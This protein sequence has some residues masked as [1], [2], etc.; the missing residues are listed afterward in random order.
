MDIVLDVIL[1][2]IL[3]AVVISS[4]KKGI[5]KTLAELVAF[6]VAIFLASQTA[7]PVASGMYK[8][9]FSKNVERGL[10][11]VLPSDTSKL[12]NTDKAKYVFEEMPEFANKQAEKCGISIG[13]VA[14]Q[15]AKSN[16]SDGDTLYQS[17]ESNI[18]KPIAVAVL[19]HV[20]F[21]VLSVLYALVLVAI[22]RSLA[23]GLKKSHLI[24]GA[25]KLVGGVIGVVKGV[26]I[27][28]LVGCLL[29][30]L[31]PRI[32]NEKLKQAVDGSS[33]VEMC[34][35]FDPME[36]ISAAE[37]FVSNIK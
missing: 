28:F 29:S 3:I 18:V 10:Y 9:F 32:E 25:D 31:E 4:A 20:M 23:K 16:F 33:I 26:V 36:A 27:V 11:E 17:L 30:Y 35:K 5:M 15:I 24:G 2:L 8:A 12:T 19:K 14:E 7:Q 21:F 6:A 37:V 1:V 13:S 22:L 34:E